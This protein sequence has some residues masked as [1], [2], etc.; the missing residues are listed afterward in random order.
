MDNIV[1]L[2]KFQLSDVEKKVEWINNPENNEFLHYDLPLEVEKTK[3][4]FE[5]N[6]DNKA[7]Y[8]AIIE[9]NNIPV[10]VIGL[11][12]IDKNKKKAEYYITLGDNN[13][14]RKGIS[15][16][17]TKQI[18]KYGFEKLEVEKIWLCVDEKNIAAR[19]LYEKVGFKLEGTLRKD[20]F[21][22]GE[23]INRCMY[24]ICKDEWSDSE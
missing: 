12:N 22:K 10:G 3:K 7:R 18:I 13:Y 4:W 21:F 8:D 16:E 14:K 20:I 9:Y 11:I 24:G 2:R 19:K 23:M 5:N 1:T 6:E 15:F 17:A